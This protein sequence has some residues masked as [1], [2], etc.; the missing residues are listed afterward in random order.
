MAVRSF[1]KH[2]QHPDSESR[3]QRKQAASR[4]VSHYELEVLAMRRFGFQGAAHQG[5]VCTDRMQSRLYVQLDYGAVV[6]RAYLL[7]VE[8][9]VHLPQLDVAGRVA[10]YGDA[11]GTWAFRRRSHVGQCIA[12]ARRRTAPKPDVGAAGLEP[13]GP[14]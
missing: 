1:E 11:R 7:S 13:G 9:H 3:P 8:K 14:T 4:P 2:A 12:P 10:L 5:V 6:E